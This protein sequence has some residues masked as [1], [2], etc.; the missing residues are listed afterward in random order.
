MHRTTARFATLKLLDILTLSG[1]T[2]LDEEKL[3]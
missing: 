2:E 1:A 3:S